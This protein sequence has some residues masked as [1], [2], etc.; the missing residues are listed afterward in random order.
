MRITQ[1]GLVGINTTT[2]G[3]TLSINGGVGI[4]SSYANSAISTGTVAVQTALGIG[5]TN[6]SYP[7]HSRW[8]SA[9]LIHYMAETTST[10]SGGAWSGW[11]DGLI[12]D[13]HRIGVAQGV[14]THMVSG[15]AR[16]DLKA[17]GFRYKADYSATWDD[18]SLVDKEY[19][20]NAVSGGGGGGGIT[21]LNG[22]TGAV[23]TFSQSTSGID[24]G[25]SSAGNIHTF[26]LP[27]ASATA[28]G[29]VNTSTQVIAGTKTFNA[30]PI[31]DSLTASLPLKLNG[32]KVVI[33]ALIDLSTDVTGVLPQGNGGT[34]GGSPSWVDLTTTQVNIAGDKGF[35]TSLHYGATSLPTSSHF[36]TTVG[37]NVYFAGSTTAITESN[38]NNSQG[39]IISN[40]IN[41]GTQFQTTRLIAAGSDTF[42]SASAIEFNVRH[43][44]AEQNWIR[45]ARLATLD[46]NGEAAFYVGN[47]ATGVS[48]GNIAIHGGNVS[49]LI[50]FET[51]TG[52]PWVMGN[53]N[54][55]TNT[56]IVSQNGSIRAHIVG[57]VDG[58]VVGSDVRKKENIETLTVLPLINHVRGASYNLKEN[59]DRRVVGVIAQEIE[60]VFPEAV[61]TD[62]TPE[63]MKSVSYNA[64]A[65]IALQGVRE[66]KQ[67]ID[68]LENRITK[69]E[70][71]I[72]NNKQ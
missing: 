16:A 38:F 53:T 4:G 19:V 40:H 32:S 42:N 55:S 49:S 11:K 39:F 62:E 64:I 12:V 31:L 69:L 5:L 3:S 67:Y 22:Q 66:L 37:T 30:A 72:K 60:E 56:F 23:Q 52:G 28:R 21:S 26:A 18:R 71:E 2:P 7:V 59:P 10:G 13:A 41:S 43:S 70:K 6:P 34:G 57:S 51:P 24:F 65:S 20:D 46:S 8:T 58:W 61:F 9:N 1:A 25:I 14:F 27:D 33:S 29:V 68:I 45:G 50:G 54:D 48:G 35:T 63:K 47:S 17:D 36:G 15:I 44:G